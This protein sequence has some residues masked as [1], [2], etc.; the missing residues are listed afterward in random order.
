M[1]EKI[2]FVDDEPS[3]LEGYKRLLGRELSIDTAVGG[4]LGLEAIAE[5]GPYAVVISDMRMPQMD[6]AQFLA[7]VRDVAPSTVRLAL[8]G[9]ADTDTAMAAVNEGNI[10]RFLTKPCSKENLSKAIE[11]ALAQHRLINAE[12]ELLEQTLR[13][14]VTVL[15]EVLSFSNPAAFGRAMRLRRFV[16]HVANKLQLKSSWQFEIAAMLS[17]LGCVTLSPELMNAA[18]AGERLAP[19]DQKKYDAHPAVAWEMLSRIP[20]MEPVAKMIANQN[21]PHPQIETGNAEEKREIAFGIQL[22]QAGLAFEGWVNRG[23]SPMEAAQR[24]RAS[25]KDC[26]RSILQCME[27]IAPSV[28]TRV[29]ECAVPDLAVGM[30]LQQD[31]NN[32]V[33]L[34]IMAKGQ[35]LTYQWIERLK[36]LSKIGVIGRRVKVCVP[37]NT[38]A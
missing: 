32:P 11:A 33:G 37:E 26:D 35:E 22:L 7:K 18:Y 6:G 9:Y 21:N 34:L 27:D 8:T 25:L 15:S 20:R 24:V 17:Q 19:E 29:Q 1:N 38:A 3:V 2:L 5:S 10:F 13:G 31:L 16:L 30:I 14:S 4:G 12:K 36:A 23:I 28:P